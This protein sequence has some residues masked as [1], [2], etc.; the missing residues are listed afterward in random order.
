MAG[1]LPLGSDEPTL[2]PPLGPVNAKGCEAEPL[3]TRHN[4]GRAFEP[5]DPTEYARVRQNCLKL[6][7]RFDRDA[8][9]ER[10]N[11]MLIALDQGREL[12]KVI[13]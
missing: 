5:Q 13:L 6:S 7:K 3:V 12:P 8:I 4:A 11:Q 2:R 9:A 1:S 10:T